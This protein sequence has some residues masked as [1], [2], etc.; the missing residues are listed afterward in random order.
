ML[1][2]AIIGPKET[3]TGG[4][5]QL[6]VGLPE[7]SLMFAKL[8]PDGKRVA[9]VSAGNIYV[10]PC[11]MKAIA[12]GDGDGSGVERVQLTSDG[13][14]T[15]VN[16]TFDWVYEEEFGCRD[17]FRWSSDSRSIAFWQCN[18]EGTGWFDIINNIDSIYPTVKHF[19]YPKAGTANSA[20]RI[21]VLDVQNPGAAPSWID[22]PGDARGNY[23]PRMEFVPGT[24]TLMIQQMNRAQNTNTLWRVKVSEGRPSAPER[25]S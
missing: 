8:S 14:E 10:E 20:V 5:R 4:R 11:S 21:G 9:Y 16:G 15:I 25:K 7:A 18:T 13:S 12:D 3:A 6:G 23:L 17:G 19:P 2:E 24:G 1:R 22:I